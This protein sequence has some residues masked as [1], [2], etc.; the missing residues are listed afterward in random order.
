[1]T[2]RLRAWAA[3]MIIC[4]HCSALIVCFVYSALQLP[5]EAPVM[6]TAFSSKL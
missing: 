1:M 4:A 3:L 2:W 6:T 5:L